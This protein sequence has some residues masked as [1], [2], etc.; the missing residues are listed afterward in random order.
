MFRSLSLHMPKALPASFGHQLPGDETDLRAT[1]ADVIQNPVIEGGQFM[2]RKPIGPP[3]L[4]A[5]PQL[6]EDAPLS[7]V[8]RLNRRIHDFLQCGHTD[9]S[10]FGVVP[11]VLPQTMHD[12]ILCVLHVKKTKPTGVAGIGAVNG[13]SPAPS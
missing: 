5:L 8:A 13:L 6:G 3:I 12:P 2:D 10:K 11:S 9:T 1:N 4:K 7:G